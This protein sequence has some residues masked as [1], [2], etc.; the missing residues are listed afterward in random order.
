MVSSTA[1]PAKD[2]MA[3]I[4]RPDS[5]KTTGVPFTQRQA[6]ESGARNALAKI[7]NQWAPTARIASTIPTSTLPPSAMPILILRL[8]LISSE[9]SRTP[10]PR[11]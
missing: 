1:T 7:R 4:T 3:T 2:R 5:V 10:G 9:I 8:W 6:F 11:Q